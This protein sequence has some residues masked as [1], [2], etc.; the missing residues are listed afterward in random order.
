MELQRLD[1][2]PGAGAPEPAGAAPDPRLVELLRAALA[3]LPREAAVPAPENNEEHLRRPEDR[4][5]LF[6]K[7]CSAALLSIS[8]MLAVTLYNGLSTTANATSA[9]AKQLRTEL[10]QLKDD[11]VS[12]QE[13]VGRIEHTVNTIKDVQANT[14]AA[15]DGWRER[16]LEHRTAVSELRLQIKEAERDLQR[17]HEEL[18]L[19]EQREGAA[20][21]TP[22][23][24]GP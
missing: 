21:P 5:P 20:P 15:V 12:N 24:K 1:Q 17:M 3:S 10:G 11:L 22:Q 18:S 6:W 8:A 9:E 16:S 19:L 23:K 4:V 13:Y 2:R 14:K 7:M